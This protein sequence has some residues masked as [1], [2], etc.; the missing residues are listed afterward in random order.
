[1]KVD[2]IVNATNN[3][4]LGGGVSVDG[5]IHHVAGK[6]LLTKYHSLNDYKTRRTKITKGYKITC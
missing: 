1:L 6:D 5:A 2:T 3:S 4:L